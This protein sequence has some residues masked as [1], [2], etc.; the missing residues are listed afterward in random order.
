MKKGILSDDIVKRTL[1]YL[2]DEKTVRNL[3]EIKFI[4]EVFPKSMIVGYRRKE[5]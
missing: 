2:D 3:P 4:L 1:Q 5:K